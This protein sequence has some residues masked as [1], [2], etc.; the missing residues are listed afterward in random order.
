MVWDCG[1]FVSR[2]P[3]L[4]ALNSSFLDTI[5]R[6]PK[7]RYPQNQIYDVSPTLLPPF[8]HLVEARAQSVFQER[9]R[10]HIQLSQGDAT[11]LEAILKAS[12]QAP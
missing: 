10:R 4:A 6:F 9:L 11:D 12:G 1:V 8:A 3:T 5:W 7:M 2:K